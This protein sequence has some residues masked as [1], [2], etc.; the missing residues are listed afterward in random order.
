VLGR[1]GLEP[2]PRY[3]VGACPVCGW[4]WALTKSGKLRKHKDYWTVRNPWEPAPWCEGSG[5][6]PTD[7]LVCTCGKAKRVHCE[8]DEPGVDHERTCPLVH[9]EFVRRKEVTR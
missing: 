1:H 6:V 4:S 5:R 3:G 8:F 7:H 9:H 2:S